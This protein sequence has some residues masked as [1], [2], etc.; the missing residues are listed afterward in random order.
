MASEDRVEG[1]LAFLEKREP[2]F[3]GH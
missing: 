3:R 1:M 2:Q